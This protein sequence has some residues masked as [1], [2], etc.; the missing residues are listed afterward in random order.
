MST[1][2]THNWSLQKTV[3]SHFRSH[4]Q[5]AKN[6]WWALSLMT[7]WV[8]KRPMLGWGWKNLERQHNHYCKFQAILKA[9]HP[10]HLQSTWIQDPGRALSLITFM[11]RKRPVLGF[12]LQNGTSARS[13]AAPAAQSCQLGP[14]QHSNRSNSNILRHPPNPVVAS[15]TRRPGNRPLS[16]CFFPSSTL[17]KRDKAP[18]G[19]TTSLGG[20]FAAFL[21]YLSPGP[22]PSSSLTDW[23]SSQRQ[24]APAACVSSN[25]NNNN[26]ATVSPR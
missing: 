20:S 23:R 11:V 26:N 24:T 6:P 4:C 7:L 16:V 2:P 3:A 22:V 19:K 25:N 17:D 5:P 14:T 18:G 8:R 1:A 10:Y 13:P 9:K 12:D 21:L 15:S